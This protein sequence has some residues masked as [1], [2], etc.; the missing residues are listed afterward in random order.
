MK[1]IIFGFFMFSSLLA[2]TAHAADQLTATIIGSGSPI[3]NENRASASTLISAGNTHILVDMGNGTQANL[4][5][6]GVDIRHLSSLLITHHHLDHNEEFVPMLIRLLLGRNNFTIV[7]P[8]NTKKLTETNLDLYEADITYRLGKTKRNLADRIKAFDVTDIQGGE[9]F[10]VGDIQVTTLQVPHTIHTV[11]YRFDYNG[12]SIVITGDLT[13]SEALPTFASNADYMIIDSGGMVMIGGRNKNKKSNDQSINK[14]SN[15]KNKKSGNKKNRAHLNLNDS[16]TLA[17]KANVKNLVYTHFTAGEV[18]AEASLKEI[19]KNYSGNVIFSEDLMAVNT[20]VKESIVK[21]SQKIASYPIVDT[22]QR[23]SYSNNAVIPLPDNANDFY[24]Q[25]ASYSTNPPSYTDN[26]NGT[27]TDN[28]TG[29]IWQKQMGDKLSYDE[30]L[31]KINTLKLAGYGDWRIPTIKELYSLIQFTGSVK[32]EK[33][34]TPFIDTSFFNQPLGNTKAGEREIDA[35]TWSS[36]EYVGKTMKSDDTVFGVNFVDG[37][38]KGY[39]KFN[40]RTKTPNK[41][42]FRF[43][44]GNKAYG[45]NNFIDN[46]DGTTTDLATGLTWQQTDSNKGLNWQQALQYSEDLTLAGHSD[47]RLPDAKEL[48]SIVDYTRSPETSN[49]AAI[50]P[51][52]YTSSIKNESG[53]KDYPYYWSS[54]THLDG[55]V[56]ESAAVY[57][58]FGKALGEMRGITMDVH[59]AGSQR[60]DPK[61]GAPMSRGPQGDFIRVENYVRSVRDGNVVLAAQTYEQPLTEYINEYGRASNLTGSTTQKQNNKIKSSTQSNKFINRFD[62]DGD[63]KV[64]A[65]EFKA[66]TK[67]FNHFDKNK[68]GYITADEAPTG[69]PKNTK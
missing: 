46:K 63:A 4:S 11:A 50:D 37:R 68:D 66:G 19:H 44:R 15:N 31:L 62:K 2:A 22:G 17:Q 43:V 21:T 65:S 12:Q 64:S 3:Y 42:Y 36:T 27:I 45:K 1:K 48:Q 35:Q 39:P 7:G 40:P 55:P 54:T 60:S 61:T 67:R 53:E 24:G 69:P 20:A 9:S 30:A 13:Y 8:P 52:F 59:G 23:K 10:K 38:I 18:D 14:G 32:G 26:N 33:A 34:L 28:V 29:L 5:K 16:S 56:P 41:M 58:A 47:W 6:L 25:D 51:I 49:S 57:V